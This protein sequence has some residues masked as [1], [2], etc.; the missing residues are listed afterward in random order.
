M[1]QQIFLLSLVSSCKVLQVYVGT[2]WSGA[3]FWK[4]GQCSKDAVKIFL[5]DEIVVLSCNFNYVSINMSD[6]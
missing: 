3:Y 2:V 6:A 5:A 1:T 4:K